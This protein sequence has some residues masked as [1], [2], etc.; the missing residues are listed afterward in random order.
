[1]SPKRPD[2]SSA[3]KVTLGQSRNEKLFG[4]YS[5]L[6]PSLPARVSIILQ[7]EIP[8]VNQRLA[9]LRKLMGE[10]SEDRF[11]WFVRRF[12][13]TPMEAQIA[14]FLGEGG[15]VADFAKANR[16]APATV[17]S[18]LKSIFRKTGAARQADLPLL[19]RRHGML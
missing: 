19:M 5:R 9:G 10:R 11:L 2:N 15:S 3:A 14:V 8:F 4:L 12:N 17:R 7:S 16:R 18:H 1:M 13:L 6:Y